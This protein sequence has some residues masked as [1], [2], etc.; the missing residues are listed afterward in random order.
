[1]GERETEAPAS[2]ASYTSGLTPF[3]KILHEGRS[4]PAS[5]SKEV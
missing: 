2:P 3:F 4:G 1:M 5:P